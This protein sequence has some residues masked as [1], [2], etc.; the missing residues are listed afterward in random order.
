[1]SSRIVATDNVIA[2][3]IGKIALYRHFHEPDNPDDEELLQFQKDN[4]KLLWI[5]RTDAFSLGERCAFFDEYYEEGDLWELEAF[6]LEDW[7]L[8]GHRLAKA[9]VIFEIYYRNR[10]GERERALTI[11]ANSSQAINVLI[12]D[13]RLNTFLEIERVLPVTRSLFRPHQAR[14]LS[15]LKLQPRSSILRFY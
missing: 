3:L 5:A 9:Q 7:F 13:N 8:D 2:Q 1:M 11:G 4:D 6:G 10:V 15:L 12:E 14:S